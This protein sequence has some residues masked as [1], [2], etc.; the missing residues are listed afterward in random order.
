MKEH[1]GEHLRKGSTYL[2]ESKKVSREVVVFELRLEGWVGVF[3][4]KK[5]QE[6]IIA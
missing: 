6:N 1:S 5:Q 2:G 3:Q 4:A